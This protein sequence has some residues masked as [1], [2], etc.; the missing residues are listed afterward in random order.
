MIP[1]NS[2]LALARSKGVTLH[3][4]LLVDYPVGTLFYCLHHHE[5]LPVEKLTE[6]LINRVRFVL[7]KKGANE[8]P[9]RLAAMRPVLNRA[10]CDPLAADYRADVLEQWAEEYP[11]HPRW[12][13]GEGLDF[14]A[15]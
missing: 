2:L 6:P 1:S 15:K 11:D 12:T 4:S 10:K 5:S 7:N 13:L 3:E 14:S 9:V 8:I